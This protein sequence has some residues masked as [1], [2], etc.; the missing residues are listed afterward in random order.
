MKLSRVAL[1]CSVVMS[2]ALPALA[3]PYGGPPPAPRMQPPPPPPPAQIWDSRGWVMLG[4]TTVN[5][6]GRV[7]HD[8]I[9]VGRQEGKFSKITLVVENGDLEMVDF[10]INFGRGEA[11]RP[12]V[13][14]FFREGTRTR[15]IDLP[16]TVWG[17]DARTI[18]SI[19][20]QYRNL[21][22]GAHARVQ[23]WAWK[24]VDAAPPPPPAPVWDSRGWVPLGEREVNGHGRIDR[25]HIE[26]GRQEGRFS[27]L[28]LVVEN[29]DL[30]L[31]GFTVNFVRGQPW[32]PQV[33]HYFREGQRTRVLEIP[34]NAWG[35]EARTIQSIDFAY[36]NLPG[37]GRAKVAVFGWREAPAQAPAAPVFNPTGWAM[38]GEN[39]VRGHGR[40]NNVRL[41]VGRELG[42]FSQLTIVVTD[43]DLELL[44]MSIGFRRGEPWHPA[45][46]HFFKEG[47]RSRVIDLPVSEWGNGSRTIQYIDLSYANVP[48]EGHARIQVWAR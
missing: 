27:K 26:V 34:P 23:V 18:R 13:S 36:R 5:G 8:S 17:N 22:R 10:A 28:T 2:A 7:D 21:L 29:S 6:R 12:R 30:E 20:F 32:M 16:D 33:S 4:E 39:E 47:Q 9:A 15:V 44:D 40:T 19:D 24:T 25:D 1:V 41:E 37:G 38:L 14:Q 45:V 3:Q 31:V 46:K 35:N 43:A 48:G 42:K 11:F